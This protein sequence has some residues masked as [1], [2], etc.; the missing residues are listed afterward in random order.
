MARLSLMTN[1]VFTLK[2]FNRNSNTNFKAS[3]SY[4]WHR[5]RKLEVSYSFISTVPSSQSLVRFPHFKSIRKRGDN[6]HHNTCFEA[7]ISI[8]GEKR[9]WELNASPSG[10]WNL[11]SFLDYRNGF[12]EV[13]TINPPEFSLQVNDSFFLF[14]LFID[15]YPWFEFSGEPELSLNVVLRHIDSSL[16]YW[17]FSHNSTHPDFHDRTCFIT[18]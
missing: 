15:L 2:P 3:A 13:Q 5:S 9:Y 18:P 7:F 1:R 14:Y 16:S 11:Y 8:P 17:S 10:E 6:L 4:S 12:K